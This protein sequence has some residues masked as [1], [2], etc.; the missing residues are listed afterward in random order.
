MV[1]PLAGWSPRT[2]R[3][4]GRPGRTQAGSGAHRSARTSLGPLR[5][6]R[7]GIPIQAASRQRSGSCRPRQTESNAGQRGFPWDSL[8]GRGGGWLGGGFRL[9]PTP[10]SVVPP[11]VVRWRPRRRR[12]RR[13]PCGATRARRSASR[14]RRTATARCSRSGADLPPP[15]PPT[16]NIAEIYRLWSRALLTWSHLCNVSNVYQFFYS[17]PLRHQL[18]YPR[19]GSPSAYQPDPSHQAPHKCFSLAMFRL[20]FRVIVTQTPSAATH[21][22]SHPFF[23][24]GSVSVSF[25]G[26]R[27]ACFLHSPNN[28]LLQTRSNSIHMLR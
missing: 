20:R 2:N 21:L 23:P 1:A 5:E 19:P 13:G 15:R 22:I 10:A 14:R 26:F 28:Y 3:D 18:W 12:R 4:R 9:R 17:A 16:R 25:L 11:S 27:T 7:G 8:E 6:G 24:F